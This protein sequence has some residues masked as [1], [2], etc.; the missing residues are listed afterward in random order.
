MPSTAGAFT[1]LK[2][3]LDPDFFMTAHNMS[4]PSRVTGPRLFT[5]VGPF[6]V[7]CDHGCSH[8]LG[9]HAVA[10]CN[11]GMELDVRETRQR[12]MKV[13]LARIKGADFVFVH[14]DETDCF[15]TLVEIGYARGV[16]VP[17]HLHFGD[18]ISAEERDAMWFAATAAD[19]RHEGVDL[20]TAFKNALAGRGSG[21]PPPSQTVWDREHPGDTADGNGEWPFPDRH[22]VVARY[23]GF[24]LTRYIRIRGAGESTSRQHR[25]SRYSVRPDA[26]A[27]S[28]RYE[29]WAH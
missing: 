19:Y 16:S 28:W 10:S 22:F 15:G 3:R 26:R 8:G 25:D 18:K 6:F 23:R 1:K 12:V 29:L 13:N 14:I 11:E 21:E 2:G 7:G 5:L 20:H 4:L 27:M 24:L 17:V 9:M